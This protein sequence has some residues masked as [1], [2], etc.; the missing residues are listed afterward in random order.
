MGVEMQLCFE[1]RIK[2]YRRHYSSLPNRFTL[3]NHHYNGLGDEKTLK[4]AETDLF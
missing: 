1:I 4:R 2:F 3:L